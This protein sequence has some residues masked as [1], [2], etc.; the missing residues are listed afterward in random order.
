[1][2]LFALRLARARAL[3]RWPALILLRRNWPQVVNTICI[4]IIIELGIY[5]AFFQPPWL[6]YTN[7]PFPVLNDGGKVHRGEDIR[8]LV[9]RCSSSSTR[10][11]FPIARRLVGPGNP[12]I[13][14]SDSV[15]IEPGCQQVESRVTAA[16]ADAPLGFYSLEG[17]SEAAGP[18]RTTIVPWRSQ[19]FE[20]VP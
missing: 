9:A 1:M 3:V 10:R 12:I 17:Y 5:F 6:S 8:L 16:S 14:K 13:V 2:P 11:I 4:I 18:L 7:S 19:Q 20:V 15:P